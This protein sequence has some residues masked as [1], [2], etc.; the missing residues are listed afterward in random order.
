M[1]RTSIPIL[2]DRQRLIKH[3]TRAALNFSDY[4]FLKSRVS[5]ALLERLDDTSHRFARCLD[6]GCHH[7]VLAENI[8]KRV[9]C[10]SVLASD[11][12][13][14]MLD[15]AR[16]RGVPTQQVDEAHLPFHEQSFDLV[17]SALSL[18]WV[19]DLLGTLIQIRRILKP[20]GLFLA[21]FFGE[22]TLHELRASLM[23]AESELT[24]GVAARVSPFASL[25]D[26]AGLM[27]RAGF[28]LPVVDKDRLTV[29]Y[30]TPFDLLRDLGGM[31]ERAAFAQPSARGLSRRIL[32]RMAQIYQRD[33]ADPDGKVRASFDIIY[34]SGW[35]P[36]PHQPQ[37][38]ARGSAKVSLA[39][40]LSAK[41]YK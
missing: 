38:K 28:A 24:G 7:G 2:F 32:M 13:P 23:E 8:S 5:N 10:D 36:A 3:R 39:E 35:A 4:D 26:M 27:Q 19:N 34:L 12:A 1:S 14:A 40:A 9:G 25:Q 33:Y 17:A 41:T 6:L 15:L 37:P 11:I 18:H 20:D 29:R 16:D 30:Q 22:A 21:A 31:G